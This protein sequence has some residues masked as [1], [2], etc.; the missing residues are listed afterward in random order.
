M[1]P[2]STAISE[3]HGPCWTT[4]IMHT[5]LVT[6]FEISKDGET[7]HIHLICKGCGPTTFSTPLV[8]LGPMTVAMFGICN[9]LDIPLPEANVVPLK[10]ATKAVTARRRRRTPGTSIKKANT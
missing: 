10:D 2:A 8:H 4:T 9:T 1:Q 3:R 5:T 6:T 7:I